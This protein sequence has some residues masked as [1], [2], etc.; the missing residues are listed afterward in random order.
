MATEEK[1]ISNESSIESIRDIFVFF[2]TFFKVGLKGI[3]MA[4][5]VGV[6]TFSILDKVKDFDEYDSFI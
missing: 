4:F 2:K 6:F 5:L 1:D 3:G